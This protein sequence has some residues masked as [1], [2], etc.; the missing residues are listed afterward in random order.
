MCHVCVTEKLI[1]IKRETKSPKVLLERL[2]HQGR[3]SSEANLP[4]C[5]P[6]CLLV[7]ACLHSE[8]CPGTNQIQK[9]TRDPFKNQIKSPK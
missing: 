9:H 6:V 8:N 3:D 1:F 4:A 2:H 5:L 7:A